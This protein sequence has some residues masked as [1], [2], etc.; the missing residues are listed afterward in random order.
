MFRLAGVARIYCH[1]LEPAKAIALLHMSF[2]MCKLPLKF[3]S[4]PSQCAQSPWCTL[5]RNVMHQLLAQI[6]NPSYMI[7]SSFG[8]ATSVRVA[9]L[10]GA[11]QA[12]QARTAAR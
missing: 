3:K 4:C 9:N 10:L 11:G 7:P 1:V 5:L 8:S 12:L 2:T 6:T